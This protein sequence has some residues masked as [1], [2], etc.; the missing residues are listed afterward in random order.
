MNNAYVQVN[1][2]IPV[3]VTLGSIYLIVAPFVVNDPRPEF[4]FSLCLAAI[5]MVCYFPFVRWNC[6]GAISGGK[7]TGKYMQYIYIFC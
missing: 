1:L 6:S 2:A 4:I 5:S 7:F 3:L